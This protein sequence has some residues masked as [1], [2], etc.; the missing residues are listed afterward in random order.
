MLS[1]HLLS[2]LCGILGA[3]LLIGAQAVVF[4]PQFEY[5]FSPDVKDSELDSVQSWPAGSAQYLLCYSKPLSSG[6]EALLFNCNLNNG[7][8]IK[9]TSKFV[10]LLLKAL[11]TGNG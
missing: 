4:N 5:F 8:K 9:P 6:L 7:C 1:F 2:C 10:I 3:D 11:L